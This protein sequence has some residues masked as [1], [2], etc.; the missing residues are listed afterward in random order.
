MA[1]EDIYFVDKNN[2]GSKSA[3]CVIYTAQPKAYLKRND[4]MQTIIRN[5][6]KEL[7]TLKKKVNKLES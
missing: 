7:D 6:I 1:V 4:T 3:G 2:A 5:T